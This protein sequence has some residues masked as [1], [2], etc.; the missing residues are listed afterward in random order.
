[1]VL[2]ATLLN[3]QHDKRSIKG[4]V[5]QSREWES[6]LLYS[7]SYR[8]ESLRVNLDKERQLTCT[9]EFFRRG[10][11]FYIARSARAVENNECFS[12]GGKSVFPTNVLYKTLNNLMVRFQQCKSLGNAEYAFIAIAPRSTLTR[13]GSPW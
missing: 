12:A 7:S 8:K 10:F 13:S 9:K 1:M 11:S 5:E 6:A 3:T 4:K 2:D